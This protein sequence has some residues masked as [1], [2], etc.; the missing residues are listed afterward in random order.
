MNLRKALVSFKLQ[1]DNLLMISI[2]RKLIINVI[3]RNNLLSEFFKRLRN[4]LMYVHTVT[5]YL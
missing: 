2:C 4:E 3:I 5:S 1:T